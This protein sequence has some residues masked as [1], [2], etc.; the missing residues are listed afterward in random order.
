[1]KGSIGVSTRIRY[2][3]PHQDLLANI[4]GLSPPARLRLRWLDYYLKCSNVTLTCRHFGIPRSLFYKWLGRYQ[5]LGIKGLEVRSTRPRKVRQ[6]EIAWEIRNLIE[7]LRRDNPAW[8]KYKLAHILKRDHN[9]VISASSVNRIYHD[10]D[11]FWSSP[12]KVSKQAKKHWAIRRIRAP[13]GLRG[14]APGSLVEI[15]LKVLNSLGTTNYQ[16]TAID[17]CAKIK[18]IQVYS[19][20]T[21]SCGSKFVEAMLDY[22]PFRVRHINSDNGGEFLNQ[23]HALLGQRKITHYFS[24]ARTPKDNP[25]VENTIKADEYEYWAWGNLATTVAELNKKAYYW[26]NKFNY[27]RPH[28]ALNYQTPME[29]YY[30]NFTN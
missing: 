4:V 28:Q 1:M 5:K 3:L 19:A 15:D 22:F 27:Y 24:R 26:M 11:L 23:C 16:F 30:A 29:Y 6:R 21:A 25:C 2:V 18:F 17:T 9:I 8:S 7:H 13:K 20:K 14:A 12:M 10:R